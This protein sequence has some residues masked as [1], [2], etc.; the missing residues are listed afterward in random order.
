MGKKKLFTVAADLN[1]FLKTKIMKQR[2][3]TSQNV[4]QLISIFKKN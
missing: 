3:T 2:T 4:Y 1:N